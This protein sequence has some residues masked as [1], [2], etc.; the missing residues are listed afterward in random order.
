VFQNHGYKGLYGGET[1][2]AIHARKRLP[3]KA[4][5][6]D[7]MGSDELA[8]NSFRASLTKQKINAYS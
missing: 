5:I 8:Y 6:L 2:N 1:E 7:Y 3:S 4:K